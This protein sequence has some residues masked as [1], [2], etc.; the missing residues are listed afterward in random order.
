MPI[1]IPAIFWVYTAKHINKLEPDAPAPP[2]TVWVTRCLQGNFILQSV[3]CILVQPGS[4]MF[5]QHK[6]FRLLFFW[7]QDSYVYYVGQLYHF[8]CTKSFKCKWLTKC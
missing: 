2:E 4:L 5:L 6:T 8:T 7:W 3:V 1:T